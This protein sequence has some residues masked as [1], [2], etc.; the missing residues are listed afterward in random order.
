MDKPILSLIKIFQN[1]SS[2]KK[3]L[4]METYVESL[5]GQYGSNRILSWSEFPIYAFNKKGSMFSKWM[6]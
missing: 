5:K 1:I 4:L 6:I 2:N 3:G